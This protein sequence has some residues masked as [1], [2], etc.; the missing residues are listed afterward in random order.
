MQI[1]ITHPPL[2]KSLRETMEIYRSAGFTFT[3]DQYVETVLA[4][5]MLPD[6]LRPHRGLF[7]KVDAT[8]PV[9][10]S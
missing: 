10:E 3:A 4:S 9:K 1:T 6:G 2:L 5:Q 8:S 7:E